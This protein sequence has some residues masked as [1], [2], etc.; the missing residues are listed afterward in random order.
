MA[1]RQDAHLDAEVGDAF[2]A[3]PGGSGGIERRVADFRDDAEEIPVGVGVHLDAG[4]VPELD[5]DD[6]G[7]VDLHIDLHGPEFGDL[8]DDFALEGAD[9]L[10][11]FALLFD[12]GGDG[13][14]LRRAEDGAAE[15]VLGLRDGGF[16]AADVE[17]GGLHPLLGGFEV[18]LSTLEGHFGLLEVGRAEHALVE[19]V[20]VAAEGEVGGGMR[21]LGLGEPGGRGGAVRPGVVEGGLGLAQ[22]AFENVGVDAGQ[23]LA[24]FDAV[25]FP[26]GKLDQLAA[27]LR[28][29]FDLDLGLDAAGGN[30]GL[31]DAV[32]AHGLGVHARGVRPA[33]EEGGNSREHDQGAAENEKGALARAHGQRVNRSPRPE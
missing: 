18:G 10:H 28:T 15:V 5:L 32:S 31:D 4:G 27:D 13:A 12:Q 16:G 8:H 20:A 30:D 3:E 17:P 2:E 29:D 11:A 22:P 14:G 24:G 26:D 21:G 6:V 7:L 25:P 19:E 23:Q 33:A 9:A 1:F